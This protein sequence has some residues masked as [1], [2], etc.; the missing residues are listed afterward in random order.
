MKKVALELIPIM[1]EE[2]INRWYKRR[3]TALYWTCYKNMEK[4]VILI[5]AYKN[6]M[7]IELIKNKTR[8]VKKK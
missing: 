7:E 4:V 3:E 8:E 1:T 6:K 5:E 2:A